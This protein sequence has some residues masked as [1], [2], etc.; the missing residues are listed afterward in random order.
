VNSLISTDKCLA[1]MAAGSEHD[2]ISTKRE[3][4]PCRESWVITGRKVWL[5]AQAFQSTC[6]RS[7]DMRVAPVYRDEPSNT[8]SEVS[9]LTIIDGRARLNM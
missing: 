8:F 3:G 4:F 7:R 1:D 5:R 2:T 6:L 9:L